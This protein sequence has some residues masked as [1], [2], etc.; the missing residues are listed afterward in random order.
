MKFIATLLATIAMGTS[1]FAAPVVD[2]IEPRAT[3]V[4]LQICGAT[5]TPLL[6]PLEITCTSQLFGYPFM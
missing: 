1:T 5:P 2:D 3:A 6:T 4:G